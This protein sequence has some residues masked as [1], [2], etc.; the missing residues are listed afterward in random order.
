M[1][2]EFVPLLQIQLEL[3]RLPRGPERFQAYLQAMVAPGGRELRL[4]PLVAM[5]PMGRE[6]LPA[7]LEAWLALDAEVLGARAAAT[8]PWDGSLGRLKLGLVIADDVKGGWT[9]RYTSEMTHRFPNPKA[10]KSGWLAG[11]LWASEAPTAEAV[12]LEVRSVIWRATYIA[13]HGAACSL[14]AMLAQEGWVMAKS[15]CAPAKTPGRLDEGGRIIAAEEI[16]K[17]RAT[18]RPHLDAT[19]PPTLIPCL[20]GD[21]AAEALGHRPLG[22]PESA[23]FALALHDVLGNSPA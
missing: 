6:H 10:L 23:G 3:Y 17:I 9:N 22:L 19:D 7:R 21:P 16:A 5:N 14:R 8:V 11:V 4:P 20:F 13:A 2:I 15:G 12:T 18:I 1:P